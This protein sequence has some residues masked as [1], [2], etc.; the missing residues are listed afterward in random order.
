MEV[1]PGP[2]DV[3]RVLL[4]HLAH[5]QVGHKQTAETIRYLSFILILTL[6]KLKLIIGL[7]IAYI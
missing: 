4:H 3:V 2:A 1:E 7:K 5:G 6:N